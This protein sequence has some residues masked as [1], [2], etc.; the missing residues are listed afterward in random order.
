MMFGGGMMLGIGLLVMLLVVGIPVLLLVVFLGGTA[1]FLQKQNQPVEVV[2]KPVY[3][4]P[5]PAIQPAQAAVTAARYCAHC[6]AG[7]QADWTH[8][9]QCGAPIS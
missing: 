5:R 4:A 3:A 7:L 6:G 2:Q 8:C 9:P 1:G